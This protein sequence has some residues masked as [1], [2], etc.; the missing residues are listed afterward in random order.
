[1]RSANANVPGLLLPAS[2]NGTQR[3]KINN[4][5]INGIVVAEC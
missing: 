4:S 2:S 5:I 3:A 1:M